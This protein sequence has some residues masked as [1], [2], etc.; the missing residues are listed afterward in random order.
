[1]ETYTGKISLYRGDSK[2]LTLTFTNVDDEAVDITGGTVVFTVKNS[3]EDA[4]EAAVMQKTVTSHENAAGGI[5]K[6][7]IAIEDTEELEPKV[8]SYDIQLTLPA[9]VKKTVA[10][11]DFEVLTDITRA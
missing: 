3:R 8:Y 11:G 6:V 2:E 5:S 1:M 9:G 7:D 4:D 10:I